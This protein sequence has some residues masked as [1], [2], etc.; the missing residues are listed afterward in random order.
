MS[1]ELDLD[2]IGPAAVQALVSSRYDVSVRRLVDHVTAL[3]AEVGRLRAEVERLTTGGAVP[4]G[5]ILTSVPGPDPGGG[6]V[7]SDAEFDGFM[8]AVH[9]EPM[10]A[11]CGCWSCNEAAINREGG[12]S[13]ISRLMIL[14]PE[15]GYKRCPRSTHHDNA[16]TGSNEYGQPGSRYGGIE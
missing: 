1:G 9:G 2:A 8:D 4:L 5:A 6:V 13:M 16:C 11:K 7:L 10:T 12:L 3:V 14:C 15:C